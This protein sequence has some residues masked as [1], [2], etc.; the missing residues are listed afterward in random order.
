MDRSSNT[1]TVKS[2]LEMAENAVYAAKLLRDCKIDILLFGCT[3]ASFIGGIS[4]EQELCKKI[5]DNTGIKTITSSMAVVKALKY[6]NAK[7]ITIVTP[8]INEINTREK[9]FFESFGFD[10]LRIRGIGLKT[11]FENASFEPHHIYRFAKQSLLGKEDALFISC[12]NFYSLPILQTL[13]DDI[14][15][16]VISSNQASLWY[17]LKIFKIN[18]KIMGFGKIFGMENFF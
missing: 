7:K 15:K 17:I 9:Q 16:F 18:S 2:Q 1:V 6:I 13:E 10:V 8:Y 4:F 14:G 12:T 3:S 11:S 5:K